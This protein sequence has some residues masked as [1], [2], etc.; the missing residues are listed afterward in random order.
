MSSL[1]F[2]GNCIT[3]HKETQTIS[4]PS[5]VKF[6][7][8]YKSAFPVKKEFVNYMSSWVLNPKEE[9]SLMHHSIQKHGLMPNLSYDL[10]TL[11][12]IS[13][14]IYETDFTKRGGKH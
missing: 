2:N 1:L 12:E 5:V 10:D 13:A 3:C 6:K 11:R 7:E 9:T 4:A 8:V 14:Y